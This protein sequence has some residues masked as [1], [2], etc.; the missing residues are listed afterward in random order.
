MTKVSIK[1]AM[2][3]HPLAGIVLRQ[4]GGGKD[5]V[6]S[7]IEAG[8]HGTDAGWPGFT[9]YSDTVPFAKRNKRA[10]LECAAELAGEMGT[11]TV[12]LVKGFQCL[13]GVEGVEAVLLGTS[14]D[15]DSTTAVY[16]ALAWFALEE[17][18]S[19]LEACEGGA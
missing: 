11:D 5:A 12:A 1:R 13:K 10:I 3:A 17:V 14:R 16:N 7:A 2:K 4:L 6:Q 15:A 8:R 18:G 9:W 19:A